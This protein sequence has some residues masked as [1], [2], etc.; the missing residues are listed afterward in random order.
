MELWESVGFCISQ[1]WVQNLTLCS[2]W[3]WES[4]INS[5]SPIYNMQIMPA[6]VR[7]KSLQSCP[8]L[9]D[10]MN[11]SPLDS[12]VRG[13]L[14]ARILEWVVMP[15]CRRS[16]PPRDQT[17]SPVAPALQADSLLLHHQGSPDNGYFVKLLWMTRNR[18]WVVETTKFV[19][20]TIGVQKQGDFFYVSPIQKLQFLVYKMG[21]NQPRGSASPPPHFSHIR[22]SGQPRVFW[23]QGSS[24][25]TWPVVLITWPGRWE[26]HVGTVPSC[27]ESQRGLKHKKKKKR[28]QPQTIWFSRAK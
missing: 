17:W 5:P 1:N 6:C 16:S 12:S 21:L 28:S 25:K 14:Q 9:W 26:A 19:W 7:A 15:S 23:T 8:A 22:E 27:E 11:W 10:P 2:V 13:I 3:L 24:L 20:Y 4:Y 18:T